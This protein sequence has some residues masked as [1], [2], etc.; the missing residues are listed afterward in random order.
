VLTALEIVERAIVLKTGSVALDIE[1][2]ALRRKED[3][4]QYF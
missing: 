4:W 3:L 2:R 1:P